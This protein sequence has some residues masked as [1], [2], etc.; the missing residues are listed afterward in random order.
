MPITMVEGF[1][2]PILH[3]KKLEIKR[4]RQSVKNLEGKRFNQKRVIRHS[5]LQQSSLMQENINLRKQINSIMLQK[6]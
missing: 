6:L 4:L 1:Y 5:K 3:D 2:Q